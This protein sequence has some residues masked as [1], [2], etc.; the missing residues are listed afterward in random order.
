[1]NE[2]VVVEP[3]EVVRLDAPT[4]ER[5]IEFASRMAT[6]LADVVDR[7]HLYQVISGR[8]YPMVEAWMTIARMDGVVA[9]EASNPVRHEDGSYEA[10]VELIRLSDGMAIGRASALCGTPDDRPWAQRAEPARRS[11]AVTR[12]TSRAMR[13]QYS[14]IMAL[15][16]YEP[17]PAEEMLA[18][19]QA[20]DVEA[21][22]APTG[23]TVRIKGRLDLGDTAD[24]QVRVTPTGVALSF[25][26]F[27]TPAKKVQVVAIDGLAMVLEPLLPGLVN[28]TVTVEGR[29]E[30]VDWTSR[31][32]QMKQY[33]RLHLSRLINDDFSVPAAE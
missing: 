20:A 11:M 28:K 22:Y 16:G 31:G 18:H 25:R 30:W 23:E 13:Q 29:L 14:W 8:K 9:R 12:A 32:Q 3:P 6:A 17:T 1:M 7:Q 33:R 10:I 2:I 27:D 4:P 26:V 5:L 15:A 19:P 24:G 21:A